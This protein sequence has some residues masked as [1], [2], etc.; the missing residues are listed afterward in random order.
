MDTE[1]K[2]HEPLE[3]D[4]I[5]RALSSG[6]LED[7][8]SVYLRAHPGDIEQAFERLEEETIDSVLRLLP[9]DVLSEW[10][11][12]LP[13]SQLETLINSRAEP[14]Q[15]EL[16][17]YLSDDELVDFLQEVEEEDRDQYFDLLED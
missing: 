9:A 6:S 4:M 12:Y 14:E 11:D 2:S 13:A 16:L 5:A 7:I 8:M 1:T 17:D 3:A 15:K 10:A